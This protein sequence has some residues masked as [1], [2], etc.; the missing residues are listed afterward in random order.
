MQ[1]FLNGKNVGRSNDTQDAL[2]KNVNNL[3]RY[4]EKKNEIL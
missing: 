1:R 4:S 2:I 3:R